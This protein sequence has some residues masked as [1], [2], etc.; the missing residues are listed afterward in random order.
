MTEEEQVRVILLGPPGAGKGTQ[1]KRL[2]EAGG[3]VHVASGDLFRKHQEEGTELGKLARS[4]MEKGELV[5]D[6]VVIRMVLERI[7]EPDAQDGYILDG[8]PRTMEQA[9]ALDETLA[10][11]HA[12][13]DRVPLM[14]VET[15]ELVRRLAWRWIC[16]Q[17]QTPYHQELAP[18]KQPEVCDLC[19]GQLYQRPDDRPEAVRRRLE[20]YEE[21]TAPL[22]EYY[23]RQGKLSRVN[24]QQEIEQVATELLKA[25]E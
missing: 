24:G 16:S 17:C 12:Q 9:K 14:E 15:E 6:E 7:G 18:P 5:P 25:V 4:Y 1:A 13:I 23:S 20:V 11:E 8:F 21:Q 19:G 10:Q 22:V 2:A 3:V